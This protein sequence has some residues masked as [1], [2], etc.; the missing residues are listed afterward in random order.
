[1]R[2]FETNLL[3]YNQKKDLKGM[4]KEIHRIRPIIKNLSCEPLVL[5]IDQYKTYDNPTSEMNKTTTQVKRI[6]RKLLTQLSKQN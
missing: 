1:M 4:Q 2:K 5:L 3:T 6:V